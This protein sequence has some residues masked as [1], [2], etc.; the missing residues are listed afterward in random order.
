LGKV[1]LGHPKVKLLYFTIQLL[2]LA[3]NVNDIHIHEKNE[4]KSSFFLIIWQKKTIFWMLNLWQNDH[5]MYFLFT[6][7]LPLMIG[8][9]DE[10]ISKTRSHFK[11]PMWRRRI[12]PQANK[13]VLSLLVYGKSWRVGNASRNETNN[14]LTVYIVNG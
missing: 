2:Q 13:Q 12:N 3:T 14:I 8:T 9:I 1:H 6:T 11:M 10:N 5:L 4:Q 7:F